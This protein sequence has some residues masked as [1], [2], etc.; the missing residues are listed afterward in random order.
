MQITSL[1]HAVQLAMYKMQLSGKQ[2]MHN[3]YVSQAF[4]FIDADGSGQVTDS[5]LR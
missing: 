5:S 3:T 1:P 2:G 4:N